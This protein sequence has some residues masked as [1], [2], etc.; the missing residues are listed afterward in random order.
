MNPWIVIVGGC[1][2]VVLLPFVHGVVNRVVGWTCGFVAC[3]FIACGI[4]ASVVT[5]ATSMLAGDAPDA[6]WQMAAW[7]AVLCA[8][9]CACYVVT[10]LG[11]RETSPSVRILQLVRDAGPDGRALPDIVHA[12]S[13]RSTIAERIVGAG[14]LGIVHSVDD[15]IVLT[16][17]G[18]FAARRLRLVKRVFRV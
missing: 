2:T 13:D 6:V 8:G 16:P 4:T 10:V 17:V 14:A 1:T 15:R 18:L 7:Q 12:L 9:L 11:L 5:L 3:V